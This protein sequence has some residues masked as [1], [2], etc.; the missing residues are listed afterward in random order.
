MQKPLLWLVLSVG[1]WLLCGTLFLLGR[2]PRPLWE[3]WSLRWVSALHS[4]AQSPSKSETEL[5]AEKNDPGSQA[6]WNEI[7]FTRPLSGLLTLLGAMFLLIGPYFALQSY[8][9][10]S[11]QPFPEA[12]GLWKNTGDTLFIVWLT[13][14]MGTQTAL[15]K[16]FAEHRP[17][18]PQE[19]LKD[20]QF[21]V[22]WQI[23]ARTVEATL[24]IGV[25][26][27]ILPHT[28]YAIYAPFTLLYACLL[29][30]SRCV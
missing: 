8:L 25:A 2:S 20:V 23:M 4:A 24:L 21:Y 27:R 15:V 10:G 14:D 11:V 29:Y 13:F 3:K 17:A 1:L 9:S 19:A 18:A 5:Q 16:Y 6:G 12:D 30:T 26:L 7:G 28:S 22:W